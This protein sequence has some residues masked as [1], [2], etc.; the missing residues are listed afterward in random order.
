[1]AIENILNGHVEPVS[2]FRHKGCLFKEDSAQW[3]VRPALPDLNR[4]EQCSPAE[5]IAAARPA[6]PRQAVAPCRRA[7]P[8]EQNSRESL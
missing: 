8:C 1:M 6:G 3:L 2:L 7:T 5:K 4:G